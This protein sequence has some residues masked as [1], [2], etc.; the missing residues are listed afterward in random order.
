MSGEN[1]IPTDAELDAAAEGVI[2]ETEAAPVEAEEKVETAPEET[3]EAK[4]E[5]EPPK[6]EAAKVDQDELDHQ[7]KS[8]LGRRLKRMEEQF[9]TL[10]QRLESLNHSPA[11]TK[12]EDPVVDNDEFIRASDVPKIMER[13]SAEKQK[14][15]TKYENDYLYATV[16][17]GAQDELDVETQDEIFDVMQKDFNTRKT[18]NPVIDAEINYR[19][20]MAKLY[21][22]KAATPKN[23]LK[24]GKPEAA[25]AVGAPTT[26]PASPATKK[27]K[28]DPYA[29]E[30]AK[31]VGMSEEDIQSALS[32]N[33]S[34]ILRKHI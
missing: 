12:E 10:M 6:E 5:E 27:I 7:E 16:S 26:T 1:A 34:T 20:A 11:V 31:S 13:I 2:E 24:G 8:R 23:P 17:L 25:L 9:G 22:T 18:G 15:Q 4:T 3:V 32:S 28:L 21:R 30:F 33:T 19:A 14:E 29:A